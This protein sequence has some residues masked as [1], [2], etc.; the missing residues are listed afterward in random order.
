MMRIGVQLPNGL[1]RRAFEICDKLG[2]D[3]ILSGESC[4]GA[5]DVDLNLLADVDVLYH[6]AHTKIVK[7]GNVI[8]VP[9]FIDFDLEK[10]A[11]SVR[12][13]PE[14]EI[15]LISTAQF[16][17]KL[18]ELKKMLQN[19]GFEVELKKG[20]DRVEY[21]GQV[22]GCNYSV[23][24][25][26]KAKA[27]VFIG[28]G[29]FHAIGASFYSGKKVYAVN[30]RNFELIETDSS[31]FL[32]TR[33][34]QVSKC[35]GLDKVGMIVSTKPGQK[36]LS[37][38]ENLKKKA[39]ERGFKVLIVYMGDITPEK[40]MNLPFDFYVNTACPR[41]TY[42]DYKRFEKPII[43]PNEFEYLLKLR[44]DLGLDEIE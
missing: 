33:A 15:A 44:E 37:L 38:A 39:I 9:Y 32:R 19:F 2:S 30:P 35:V 40:L 36:R 34:I 10:V 43:S 23:L 22:L 14:R 5:C 13:I 26:S 20:G 6:Y 27:V 8:Y 31:D 41:I 12:K 24:R 4:F 18:F 21:P 42:D 7:L 17:H 3:V 1:K 25:D 29:L 28:D 11:E 16:C